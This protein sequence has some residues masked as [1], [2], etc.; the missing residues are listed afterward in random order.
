MVNTKEQYV[1]FKLR[2]K[3]RKTAKETN[4]ILKLHLMKYSTIQKHLSGLLHLRIMH[5]LVIHQH[6]TT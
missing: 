6:H 4:G 1:S 2:V 3:L 5:T